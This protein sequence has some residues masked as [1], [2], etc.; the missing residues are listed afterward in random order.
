MPVRRFRSIAE[1]SNPPSYPSGSPEAIEAMIRLL[2]TGARFRNWR[3]ESGV[4]KFRSADEMFAT[5][6]PRKPRAR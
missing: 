1:M 2:D 4:Y 5:D 6:P 3:Y